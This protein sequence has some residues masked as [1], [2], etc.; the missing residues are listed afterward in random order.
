MNTM[1][2]EHVERLLAE[3]EID[4]QSAELTDLTRISD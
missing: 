2:R 3:Y 1:E 4:H